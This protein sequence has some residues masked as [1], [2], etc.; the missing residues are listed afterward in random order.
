[1]DWYQAFWLGLT[2]G[3]TEFFP[4]SSSGHLEI[5]QQVLGGRSPDFHLF[6]EFINF[7][8]LLALL[9]F[10]RKRIAKILVDIFKNR[11]FTLALNIIITSIP[12]V[13]IGMLL[14]H[15]IESNCFFS[16]MIVI[17]SAMGII[18]LA[19]I[20]VDRL[21]K[22][23]K[24]TDENHLTKPRALIIGLA[25]CVALIPGVS[26]SGSTMLAGRMVGMDAKS[27][28]DYSFLV[29]IPIMFGVM[30]KSLLS[31]ASR[32]Y[33]KENMMMLAFANSLAFIVGIVTLCL[34]IKYLRKK[35]SLKAFGVYRV[36]VALIIIV[37]ELIR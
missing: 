15:L 5:V 14:A 35:N 32:T 36:V 30:L 10:Y 19:M 34:V 12:A 1:M 17:A 33:I 4:I 16:N 26:R 2:Q 11:N 7:G 29:S 18:G 28:A 8:T 13:L 22:M 6:L 3:L 37:F 9:V 23:S 25:Q 31:G 21:P 27:S 24:I 20:F